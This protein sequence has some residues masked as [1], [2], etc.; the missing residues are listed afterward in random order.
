LDSEI[1]TSLL[2][3]LGSAGTEANAEVSANGRGESEHSQSGRK[4]SPKTNTVVREVRLNV[5][6]FHPGNSEGEHQVFTEEAHSMLVREN[7]GVIQLS[8]DVTR[9]QLL[10]LANAEARHEVVAQVTRTYR[11]MNRCVELEFAEPAP[12]FWG[13]E[14]SAATALLP[15]DPKLTAASALLSGDGSAEESSE[16]PPPTPTAEEVQALKQAAKAGMTGAPQRA[17]EES[18]PAEQDSAPAE[19]ADTRQA[20]FPNPS[21]KF[22]APLPRSR[23]FLP[24]GRLTPGAAPRLM[25]L[26]AALVLTVIGAV[27]YTYKVISKQAPKTHSAAA[28]LYGEKAS[29]PTKAQEAALQGAGF[30]STNVASGAPLTSAVAPAKVADSAAQPEETKASET[31]SSVGK[32]GAAKTLAAKRAAAPPTSRPDA[33]STVVSIGEGVI[34]PAKLI[35]SIRAVAS[36]DSLHDFETGNVVIDAVVNTEGQVIFI[37]VISGPPSLR[38]PAV[39]AVKQYRYEPATRN[40]QPIPEHVHITVRF[41]FES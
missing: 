4:A 41:R 21:L 20:Q 3:R 7:G 1:K 6:G 14:F 40:G 16:P 33:D 30:I 25:L 5:T 9:G 8:T 39:E 36:L 31:E 22:T 10:L 13:M 35:K 11:P 26:S 32:T 19:W 37:G 2:S 15:K 27:W 34:V 17:A 23:R 28:A 38:K 29:L 24:R 12:G 18:R